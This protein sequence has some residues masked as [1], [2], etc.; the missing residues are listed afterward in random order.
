MLGGKLV[1]TCNMNEMTLDEENNTYT[2]GET[3]LCSFTANEFTDISL[4]IYMIDEGK[5]NAATVFDD[6]PVEFINNNGEFLNNI[7]YYLYELT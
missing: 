6:V 7:H 5:I 3:N 1:G 4:D 2:E